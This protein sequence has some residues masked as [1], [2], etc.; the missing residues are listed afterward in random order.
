MARVKS[1]K[2]KESKKEPKKKG[3]RGWTTDDQDKFLSSHIPSYLSAQ[4]SKTSSDFWPPLWEQYF[5]QWPVLSP[6]DKTNGEDKAADETADGAA[7]EDKKPR[8][9]ADMK[10]V[11]IP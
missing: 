5:E 10:Q 1:S 11:R 8:N 6:P 2:K 9:L 7:V 3:R 4:T